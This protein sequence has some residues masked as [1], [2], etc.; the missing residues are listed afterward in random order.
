MTPA[1]ATLALDVP[2][3]CRELLRSP[4]AP[5]WITEGARKA[6]AAATAGLCCVSVPGVWSWA[7]RL[8]REARTVLPDL[9]RIAL[10]GR[11]VVVAFDSDAMVKSSVRA[12]LEALVGYLAS[13]GASAYCAYLPE[14][15]PGAKTG[16]DDFLTSHYG[17]EDL[18]D[19]VEAELRPP[20]VQQ[21]KRKPALPTARLLAYSENVL[22]M[23][24]R[25]PN[26]G[27]HERTTLALYTLHTWAAEHADTTP[28]LYV[29]S[30]QRQSGKT[31]LLEVLELVCREPVRASSVT[32]AAIFQAIEAWRPTLLIDEVDAAAAPSAAV[33][34]RNR[35]TTKAGEREPVRRRVDCHEQKPARARRDRP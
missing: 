23:H 5:L 26:D 20:P 3:R 22:R 24:V 19:T 32:E 21:R 9:Q 31:R 34:R 12:A 13:Q 18:W 8:N 16:L 14:L 30:P 11:K 1:G 17:V 25:F 35:P 33:P 6:D 15:E 2:P 10:D 28:Y 29:K 27:R 4:R 7:K